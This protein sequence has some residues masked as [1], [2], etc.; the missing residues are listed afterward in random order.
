[1]CMHVYIYA[2]AYVQRNGGVGVSRSV[3]SDSLGPH[4]PHQAPLCMGF[5]GKNAGVKKKKKRMLEW[6]AIRML[7]VFFSILE[8]VFCPPC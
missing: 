8:P 6:V 5:S 7:N 3:V 4:G 1:M 2:Y